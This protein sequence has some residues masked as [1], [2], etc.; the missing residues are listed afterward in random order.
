MG[1]NGYRGEGWFW[2]PVAI[3]IMAFTTGLMLMVAREHWL[4]RDFVTE[5][6][7]RELIENEA[8]YIEDRKY[9]LDKLSKIEG[10]VEFI[11]RN[12]WLKKGVSNVSSRR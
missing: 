12:M 8:P 5:A 10:D 3:A 7:A 1:D 9:I 6:Q 4:I 2:K 11:K